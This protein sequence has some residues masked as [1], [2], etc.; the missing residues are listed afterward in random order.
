MSLSSL[1]PPSI[2]TLTT[3]RKALELYPPLVEKVYKA[4]LKNDSKKVSDALERDR[5]RFEEL[6]HATAERKAEFDRG[7]E[8]DGKE[9]RMLKADASAGATGLTKADVERLVQWKM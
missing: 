8:R 2:L 3:F 9:T 4:K 6:P 7:R 1:P 5:W